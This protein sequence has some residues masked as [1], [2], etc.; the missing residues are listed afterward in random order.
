LRQFGSPSHESI[1]E[2]PGAYGI[3]VDENW[4]VAVV[5]LSAGVYLPGGGIE[6]G[7]SPVQALRREVRE[8]TGM[9]IEILAEKGIARQYVPWKSHCYNKVGHYFVCRVVTRGEA[10]E[11]DHVLEWWPGSRAIRELSHEAQQ[12]M[13]QRAFAPC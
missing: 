8:E 10:T 11:I 1:I 2:R 13:V 4:R 5:I 12:W 6:A 7:E 3:I 9:E